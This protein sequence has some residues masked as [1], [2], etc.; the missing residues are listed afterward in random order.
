ME[1]CFLKSFID[2]ER[3]ERIRKKEN[4]QLANDDFQIVIAPSHLD[5]GLLTRHITGFTM[6][7]FSVD[8]FFRVGFTHPR[9]PFERSARSKTNIS[10][11]LST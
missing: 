1:R 8:A 6:H 7:E 4:R 11:I 5:L 9:K 3:F 10:L 2:N